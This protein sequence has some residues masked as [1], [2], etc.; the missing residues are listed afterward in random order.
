[1]I[2]KNGGEEDKHILYTPSLPLADNSLHPHY[3]RSGE[4]E[5]G[6]GK[7]ERGIRKQVWAIC[8]MH[9]GGSKRAVKGEEF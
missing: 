1:M 3:G 5:T 4:E 6:N 2:F 8:R 7:G 9:R